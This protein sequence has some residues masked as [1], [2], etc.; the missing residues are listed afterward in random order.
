MFV[1]DAEDHFPG[2]FHNFYLIEL[3]ALV[4]SL[5]KAVGEQF[6]VKGHNADTFLFKTKTQDVYIPKT[7]AKILKKM[8]KAVK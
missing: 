5:E 1:H 6:E 4:D 2:E 7:S 3:T 8:I